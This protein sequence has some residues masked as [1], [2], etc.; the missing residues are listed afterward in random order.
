[1]MGMLMQ[2]LRYAIRILLKSPG[3]AAVAILTLALGI[4]ANT[5]IF[6][7]MNATLLKPL[8]YPDTD[9]L[10]L[11]W[12]AYGGPEN[13]NI[14]S[15]PN[16][17]DVQK[18][19]TVLESMAWFDSA[20]KGYNLALGGVPERVSGVRV[21]ASFFHVLGVKPLLGRAFLP[22]E[23][24]A[25]RD[26]EV[27]LSYPLW[28][29][30]FSGDPAIIGKQITVDG[31]SHTVVGVM[32]KEFEFQFGS[33]LR[34]LWVPAGYTN[35]DLT[36]RG[37][38]SFVAIGRLKPGVTL[39]QAKVDM[40]TIGRRLAKQYPNDDTDM[41][42]A[43]MPSTEVGMGGLKTTLWALFAAVGFVLLIACVNVANLLLARGAARQ[44]ELAIRCALG[45]TRRRIAR[46]LITESLLLGVLGGVAGLM[47]A[48]VVLK[49][50]MPLLPADLQYLPFRHVATISIDARVFVFALVLSCVTGVLFGL[51]P[52]LSARQ[53]EIADP[54]KE[55]SGHG[56]TSAGGNRLRHA[57]IAAEMALALIVLAGAALM[58]DSMG[59]LLGVNP[60]LNPKNVLT[61][62]VS[63]AQE[64]LYVGLPADEHFCQELTERLGA[65]PGVVS[66]GAVAHL[67]LSGANAGR[68]FT[69]EGQPD[70][71]PRN[72]PGAGYSVA[73]PGFFRTLNIPMVQGREFTDA[74]TADSA[75]VVVM[76]EATARR[77]WPKGDALGAHI[78]IGG[79]SDKAPWLTVVGITADFRHDGL[80]SKPRPYFYRPFT[81]AG[82][83]VMT[84]VMRTK[85]AP[86]SFEKPARDALAQMRGDYPASGVLTMEQIVSDSLGSRRFPMLLLSAFALVAL[87][88]SAV[89]I[90][91]VVGYSVVQRTHE[92]GIRMALGAQPLDVLKL[93]LGGSMAWTLGGVA[94]GIAGA[95]ALTRLLGDLLY[96]V[97]PSDPLVLGGT[98]AVL[99]LVAFAACYLPARRAMKVDPMIALRYE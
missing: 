74:D 2:D 32:P 65:I 51:A 46:Q 63:T 26:H 28:Q 99:V 95:M 55:G 21:T 34:E 76:N 68:G 3:F 87:A 67:P 57:L 18:Q 79:Y 77:Y 88:L 40:D 43:V 29:R 81:Q 78:K 83:P 85:T 84:V 1:M 17:R 48:G 60:G 38:N 54:L 25:G 39:E 72:E 19:N 47:I 73:C 52:A 44:R 50:V 53:Q 62:G 98:A 70:P 69:I 5:A 89:G 13:Y 61:M 90:A 8:P 12:Q 33:R 10:V 15:L 42:V 94:V 11:V 22:E 71:G 49:L 24:T 93:V 7:V 9:R 6:S 41:S 56:A 59:R 45:A 14:V 91:G 97:Q 35:N 30:R 16:M 96:G 58:I 23:E 75:G 4:G 36:D 82:W 92:I 80:D 27:I 64:N 86:G 66:V 20:G 31:E 37:S